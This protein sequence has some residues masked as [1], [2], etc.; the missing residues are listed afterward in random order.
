[1]LIPPAE[2]SSVFEKLGTRPAVVTGRSMNGKTTVVKDILSHYQGNVFVLDV[3]DE[4]KELRQ[5]DLGDFF[6][7]K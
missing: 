5:L 3:S 4:N 6:G 2:D 7:L 1:V